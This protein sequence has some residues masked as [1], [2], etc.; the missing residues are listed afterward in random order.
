MER[1]QGFG[2]SVHLLVSCVTC[3]RLITNMC[4]IVLLAIA[5]FGMF[6]VDALATVT[7]R[8]RKT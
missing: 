3:L 2:T 6:V 7:L 4:R 5:L 8:L 1:P